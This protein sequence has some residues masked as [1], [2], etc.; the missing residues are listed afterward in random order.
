M[1]GHIRHIIA[2]RAAIAY[3]ITRSSDLQ[4]VPG[5]LRPLV[6]AVILLTAAPLAHARM[7]LIVAEPF[8]SFGTVMP[9]G[10]ASVYFSNLCVETPVQLRPCRPGEM[11]AVVSRYHDLRHPDLDWMAFP[12]PVFLYGVDDP[13]NTALPFMTP[14]R[15][16]TM[17][18]VYWHRYL[19]EYIPAT[20]DRHGRT[21]PPAYGDWE[22]GIGAA[23]DR[24]LLMYTFDTTAEQDTVMLS[25]LSDRPNRRSYTLTRHNC[26][27]FAADLLRIALPREA[28]HRNVPA[29]FDMT[30]P[31][32][33]A[34]EVDGYG[35]S[36]PELH[37]GVYEIPQ[38]PGE[39]RRSRPIRGAA[40]SLLTTKRYM[41][42]LLVIQPEIILAAWID[43]EKRGKWALG[44]D[45]VTVGPTFWGPSPGETVVAAQEPNPVSTPSSEL[46]ATPQPST[47]KAEEPI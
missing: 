31:K 41:A 16:A 33:L 47:E 20:T 10:H 21:R 24:R 22:E 9:Q 43:Y 27:D 11:G 14:A 26:A 28:I 3:A 4:S 13:A 8:G 23:Y 12:L 39:L 1:L 6:A 45:A 46:V 19:A 36:H 15:E 38:L 30:T 32:Q 42:T 37:L 25:W 7:G 44:Q 29:D 18:E 35:L 2:A 17:R 34:R 40:E 5:W